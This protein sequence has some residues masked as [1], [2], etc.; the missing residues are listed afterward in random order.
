MNTDRCWE[1]LDFPDGFTGEACRAG[2]AYMLRRLGESLLTDGGRAKL[3][4]KHLIGIEMA[5]QYR[6]IP[7]ELI[8]GIQHLA[9]NDMMEIQG[10]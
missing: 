2:Y 3:E 5:N 1:P 9:I 4:E 10:L 6:A 7:A 8:A